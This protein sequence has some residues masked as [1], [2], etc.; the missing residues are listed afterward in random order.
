VNLQTP[1]LRKEVSTI[2]PPWFFVNVFLLGYEFR[3]SEF[4]GI[5]FFEQQTKGY[6]SI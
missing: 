5:L 2:L 1:D 6:N 3:F 4:E